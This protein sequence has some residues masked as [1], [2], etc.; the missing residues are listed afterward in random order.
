MQEHELTAWLGGIEVTDEQRAA[1]HRA[2]D[3]IDTRYPDLR[4]SAER[5]FT[6]AAQVILGDAALGEFTDEWLRARAAERNAHAAF[7][8]AV[9]AA[10]DTMT[11]VALAAA[12]GRTRMTI[13]KALGK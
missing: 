2:A 5:A 1:L 12:T 7:T 11:E 4:D 3:I 6:T 10:S 9:I 13:R 8:G